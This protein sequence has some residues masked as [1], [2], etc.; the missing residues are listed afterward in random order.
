MDR[1]LFVAHQNMTELILFKNSVVKRQHSTAGIPEYNIN[2]VI[3]QCFYDDFAAG[4]THHKH[5]NAKASSSD[6]SNLTNAGGGWKGRDAS[7]LL[8]HRQQK[9][10]DSVHC[11]PLGNR[12]ICH[13]N[14]GGKLI[15]EP[16][17]L[18]FGVI[19]GRLTSYSARIFQR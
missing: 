3:Y 14:V 7:S 2:T 1:R 9:A 15:A 13:F 19:A 12:R 8:R 16:S 5:P 10:T 17:V 11:I 6:P 4:Q 18:A